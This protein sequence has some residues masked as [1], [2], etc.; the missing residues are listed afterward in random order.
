MA[1]EYWN[2]QPSAVPCSTRTSCWEADTVHPEISTPL[3]FLSEK[4][5]DHEVVWCRGLRTWLILKKK[6][7]SSGPSSRI[8]IVLPVS[9]RS[10]PSTKHWTILCISLPPYAAEGHPSSPDPVRLHLFDHEGVVGAAQTTLTGDHQD[11][12]VGDLLGD[13]QHRQISFQTG[14]LQFLHQS[15]SRWCRIGDAGT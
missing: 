5:I 13:P 4:E 2:H 14:A 8:N 6:H 10:F 15:C 9:C 12:D 3:N 7:P 1:I 11:T